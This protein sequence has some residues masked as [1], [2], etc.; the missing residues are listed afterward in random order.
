MI[1]RLIF[2][3]DAREQFQ[4]LENSKGKQ[5]AFKTVCKTLAFIESNLRHPSLN[6]HEFSTLK[7]SDGENVFESYAQNNTQVLI[8]YFGIMG[9]KKM[10]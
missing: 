1:F 7:G 3:D 2:D 10:R 5:S 6:T 9:R 8:G 4:E